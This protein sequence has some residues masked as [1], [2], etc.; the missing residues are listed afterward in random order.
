MIQN[1]SNQNFIFL[2]CLFLSVSRLAPSHERNVIDYENDEISYIVNW[3]GHIKER[4]YIRT[5]KLFRN[6][7]FSDF[8]MLIYLT[9]IVAPCSGVRN[10]CWAKFALWMHGMRCTH[11]CIKTLIQRWDILFGKCVKVSNEEYVFRCENVD[12]L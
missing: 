6:N 3:K 9:L 2:F 8:S 4:K 11:R 5:G 7:M 12:N 1:I 10:H